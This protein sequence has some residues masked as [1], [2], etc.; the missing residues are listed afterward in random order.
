[1]NKPAIIHYVKRSL[2]HLGDGV[3][4]AAFAVDAGGDAFACRTTRSFA[5]ETLSTNV[6]CSCAGG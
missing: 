3:V 4:A 1:M 6:C 2:P 5:N